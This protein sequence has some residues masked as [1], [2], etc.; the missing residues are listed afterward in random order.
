MLPVASRALSHDTGCLQ[1][2]RRSRPARG[3]SSATATGVWAW[4]LGRR[5][6]STSPSALSSPSSPSSESSS[7][8]LPTALS[9]P[10]SS[11]A[12]F[13]KRAALRARFRWPPSAQAQASGRRF[14]PRYGAR[15]C[16]IM[17][18]I[19]PGM[20]G[21]TVAPMARHTWANSSSTSG[22]T[23]QSDAQ[24]SSVTLA[25]PT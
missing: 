11:A 3:G 10:C 4:V 25:S 7:P 17:G 23:A 19:S 2:A 22:A 18:T 21:R 9:T 8:R 13:A 20:H 14:V 5:T 1:G 12:T 24:R 6:S 15:I 16:R